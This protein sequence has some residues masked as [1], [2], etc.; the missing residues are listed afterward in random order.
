MSL[1]IAPLGIP[2]SIPLLFK[3]IMLVLIYMSHVQIGLLSLKETFWG[4]HGIDKT[5]IILL[6]FSRYL[7][8]YTP[9]SARAF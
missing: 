1:F 6:T 4:F 5:L 7:V 3:L 9:Y 8:L 2:L